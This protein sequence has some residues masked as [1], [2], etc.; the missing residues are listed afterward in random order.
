MTTSWRRYCL[1]RHKFLNVTDRRACAIGRRFVQAV[2]VTNY[3]G[4]SLGAGVSGRRCAPLFWHR[5]PEVSAVMVTPELGDLRPR[6][7]HTGSA[8]WP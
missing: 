6:E 5:P 3:G 1:E 7:A 8:S 2:G 4:I